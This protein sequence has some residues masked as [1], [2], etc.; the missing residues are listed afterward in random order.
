MIGWCSS[1]GTGGVGFET[2]G[3]TGVRMELDEVMKTTGAVREFRDEAVPQRMIY[4]ILD[5]ARF[6]PSGGNRQPWRVIIVNDEKIRHRIAEL[7]REG[8]REYMTHVVN[9]LVPF[10]PKDNGK[11]FGSAVD[12]DLAATVEYPNEFADNLETVPVLMVLIVKLGDLACLDNGL[13]R[14]SIVG[15]GSIYPFAHNV[16]LSA[17]SFGLG[18]VMTTVICRREPQMKEL[19]GVDDDYAVAGL[20]AVG[21]PTKQ[22]TKLRRRSV[23]EITFLNTL[24]IPYTWKESQSI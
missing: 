4:E 20:V 14:Q 9:G 22:V 10:A 3:W 13:D 6:A 8:W 5:L 19:L 16:L 23:E 17:R 21:F 15:G 12:L 11:W 1:L 24:E 18:G 7:Y 2:I